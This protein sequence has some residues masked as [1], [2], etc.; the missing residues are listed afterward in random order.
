MR[1]LAMMASAVAVWAEC[2]RILYCVSAS[3]HKHLNV[4]N[5]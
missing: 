5:F 1:T 3:F 4:A 2:N